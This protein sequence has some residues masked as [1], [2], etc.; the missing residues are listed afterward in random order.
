MNSRD[1]LPGL[2]KGDVRWNLWPGRQ[3]IARM[4][5]LIYTIAPFAGSPRTS[6]PPGWFD[7]LRAERRP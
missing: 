7:R 5:M 6:Q 4:Y 3:V 2:P 1:L